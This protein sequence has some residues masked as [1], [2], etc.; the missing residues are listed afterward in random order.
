[1]SLGPLRSSLENPLRTPPVIPAPWHRY[2][3]LFTQAFTS[4]CVLVPGCHSVDSKLRWTLHTIEIRRSGTSKKESSRPRP[5]RVAHPMPSP[6]RN[7]LGARTIE[8][9]RP[10]H[11]SAW[12]NRRTTLCSE[13]ISQIFA[14]AHTQSSTDPERSPAHFRHR[15]PT[16]VALR[17]QPTMHA[18]RMTS[19][20]HTIGPSYQTE[21]RGGTHYT[22]QPVEQRASTRSKVEHAGTADTLL[23]HENTRAL[24]TV[25]NHVASDGDLASKSLNGRLSCPST[26]S[27]TQ[28]HEAS[29]TAQAHL[30]SLKKFFIRKLLSL[31]IARN[32]SYN[33]SRYS[34]TLDLWSSLMEMVSSCVR[35]RT[36]VQA[37]TKLQVLAC[38]S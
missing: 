6:S 10:S 24:G 14:V 3:L 21:P 29:A 12:A 36:D 35:V 19:P 25:G 32:D 34:E 27:L 20:A 8:K 33:V 7:V 38:G 37:H 5:P 23:A 2:T 26:C 4:P 17:N 15:R 18:R 16:A 1:M 11:P 30:P 31:R 28:S 22:S 9:H 13:A